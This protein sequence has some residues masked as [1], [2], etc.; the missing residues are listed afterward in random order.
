MAF[1][2]LMNV[3]KIW[4][5]GVIR[6]LHKRGLALRKIHAD[7]V[8]AFLHPPALLTVK[9]A[10]EFKRDRESLEDDPRLGRS[11]QVQNFPQDNNKCKIFPS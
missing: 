10:A 6:Y 9:W 8:A 4:H 1:E 5:C 7:V 3:D 2:D 11:E